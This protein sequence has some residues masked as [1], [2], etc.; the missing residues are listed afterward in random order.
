M[1]GYQQLVPAHVG[2]IWP[3]HAFSLTQQHL[4]RD[5][6]SHEFWAGPCLEVILVQ[7]VRKD[8]EP[9]TYQLM[10][11]VLDRLNDRSQPLRT[12]TILERGREFI[13][14]QD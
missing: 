1:P 14:S 3:S 11:F 8:N 6:L 9:D 5:K 10:P 7:M 12:S 4:L 2:S 13:K